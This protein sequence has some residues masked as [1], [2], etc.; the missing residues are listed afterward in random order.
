MAI[1]SEDLNNSRDPEAIRKLIE[2]LRE[3]DLS[4]IEYGAI[5]LIVSQILDGWVKR[6]RG[7]KLN[8]VYRV[9]PNK[10]N[11]SFE[12]ISKLCAPTPKFVTEYGRLNTIGQPTFYAAEKSIVSLWE[13]RAS[14]GD[15][16]T[17]VHFVPIHEIEVSILDLAV[18][19]SE[20]AK[21]VGY[22]NIRDHVCEVI[23]RLGP[24]F[25]FISIISAFIVDE[26]K[27]VVG[28]G[29][30]LNYKISAAIA[31][32][33]WRS[34]NKHP[35]VLYPSITRGLRGTNVAMDPQFV[36]ENYV[37]QGIQEIEIKSISLQ[38][39]E[40][41]TLRYSPSS[42]RHGNIRWIDGSNQIFEVKE[43]ASIA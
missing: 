12:N 40:F 32:I 39:V 17:I 4:S 31:D 33:L 11:G 34:N 27:K 42:D 14:I 26:M 35:I 20:C 16:V 7:W 41:R 18:Y 29:Q 5:R 9:R 21:L 2:W 15:I 38:S 3:L 22:S 30:H 24:G 28:D 23:A 37:I 25:D 43:T 8:G 36:I 10:K 6:E 19:E 1:W 13:S